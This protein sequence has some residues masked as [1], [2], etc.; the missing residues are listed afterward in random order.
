MGAAVPRVETFFLPSERFWRTEPGGKYD[1]MRPAQVLTI[2]KSPKG[3]C[4]PHL[5]M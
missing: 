3:P 5:C 4:K 2:Y 1:A